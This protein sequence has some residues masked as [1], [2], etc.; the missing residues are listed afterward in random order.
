M[1]VGSLHLRAVGMTAAGL[2]LAGSGA[3]APELW[4]RAAALY[5]PLAFAVGAACVAAGLLLAAVAVTE[6]RQVG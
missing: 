4:W 3:L 2:I 6:R 5:S 1:R